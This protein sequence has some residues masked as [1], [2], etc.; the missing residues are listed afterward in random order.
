LRNPLTMAIRLASSARMPPL[1]G[2]KRKLVAVR[3]PRPS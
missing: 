1:V 3:R 2:R